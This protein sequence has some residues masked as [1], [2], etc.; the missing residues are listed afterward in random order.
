MF[1]V[2]S[3]YLCH[4]MINSVV[5]FLN[6]VNYTN[7]YGKSLL[8]R[9]WDTRWIVPRVW[10]MRWMVQILETN[11]NS[12]YKDYDFKIGCVDCT[13]DL[14]WNVIVWKWD[15]S[16]L[17]WDTKT[18]EKEVVVDNV[19]QEVKTSEVITKATVKPTITKKKQKRK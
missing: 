8:F 16:Y 19:S 6:D 5:K 17:L 15:I 14:V 12:S 7:K 2:L 4:N 18:K 13:D 11:P 9:K 10:A 3:S 1:Q